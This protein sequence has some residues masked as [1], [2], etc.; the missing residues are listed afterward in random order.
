MPA[1]R[2]RFKAAL[3][4][5]QPQIGLWLGLADSYAAEVAAGAGFDWLLI[6]GEHAPND[7]RSILAQLQA[8]A[9]YPA[10][11]VVRPPIGEIHRLKQLLD[12]GAQTILV[13]MIETADHARAMVAAVRYP[14][15]RLFGRNLWRRTSPTW[16]I[17][18]SMSAIPQVTSAISTSSIPGSCCA[19]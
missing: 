1:P 2:N 4:D 6:D 12:I 11:A 5:R 19:I 9:A 10:S 17:A 7:N 15:R 18:P 3:K 13:P 8:I 14:P 16:T